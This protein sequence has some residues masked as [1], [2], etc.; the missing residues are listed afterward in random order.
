[1]VTPWERR[2]RPARHGIAAVLAAGII[3][4]R[5]ASDDIRTAANS[6]AAANHIPLVSTAFSSFNSVGSSD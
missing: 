2:L 3:I 4:Y 5:A 1:M 6:A